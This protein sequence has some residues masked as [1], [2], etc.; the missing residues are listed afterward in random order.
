MTIKYR[1]NSEYEVELFAQELGFSPERVLRNREV[2]GCAEF[3]FFAINK[4]PDCELFVLEDYSVDF[5]DKLKGFGFIIPRFTK[6]ERGVVNWYG[7]LTDIEL[8]K[9]LNSKAWTYKFLEMNNLLPKDF[10]FLTSDHDL[11]KID[12]KN[13][14]WLLKNCFYKAGQGFEVIERAS[15]AKPFKEVKVLEPFYERILDYSIHYNPVTNESF[16]YLTMMNKT[17]HYF[18]GLIFDKNEDKDIYLKS[19]DAL[20]DYNKAVSTS[21]SLLEELKK[22]DLQQ[23]LTID[24]FLF[25]DGD[26]IGI[27]PLCEVNYRINMGSLL[28]ELRNFLPES[29]VGQFFELSFKKG[30]SL[31]ES[32]WPVYKKGDRNGFMFL[33]PPGKNF[34]YLFIIAQNFKVLQKLKATFFK[35]L[36]EE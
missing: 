26:R 7:K 19:L 8:E 35:G 34:V 14:K 11:K 4:D 13:R 32:R 30:F 12:F 33:N 31:D 5:I 28:A 24:G 27:Y 6:D 3:L 2:W 25:K 1:V 16:D 20:E 9:N 29:G 15:D 22:F 21:I 10:H 18:G 23:N 36:Y 17:G